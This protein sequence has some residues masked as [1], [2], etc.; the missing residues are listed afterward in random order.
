MPTPLLP[1]G[2]EVQ[3]H[4]Y[5]DEGLNRSHSPGA[6]RAP[7][8]T[9]GADAES[10]EVSRGFGGASGSGVRITKCACCHEL[11]PIHANAGELCD[12]CEEEGG[13]EDAWGLD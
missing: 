5:D 7:S 2:A 11:A 3:P 1:R 8:P 10:C 12:A 6:R 13:E 9:P 4:D